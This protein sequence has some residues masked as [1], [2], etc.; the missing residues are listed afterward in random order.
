MKFAVVIKD[1]A[2]KTQSRA[3][4]IRL[5]GVLLFCSLVCLSILG[6]K[7]LSVAGGLSGYTVIRVY[8]GDTIRVKWGD[9]QE[10]IRL[11]GIDAPE[12]SK[13]KGEPGQ[14][15]SRKAQRHLA[16]L[17]LNRTVT[18][19]A[20]G[21]D[22]YERVLAIVYCDRRD[23]NHAMLKAGMAEVY[24][25]RTPETFDKAPYLAA[26]EQARRSQTGMWRQ[27]AAYV[28]PIRWKHPR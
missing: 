26:E 21:R 9:K 4:Y 20:Y 14:P 12:T 24:R 27:G 18:L 13:G 16:H 22:R 10:T 6:P 23:V 5:Y 11:L 3:G 28:S 15:Y 8:D 1:F 7:E 17:V 19:K 2:V 25:G